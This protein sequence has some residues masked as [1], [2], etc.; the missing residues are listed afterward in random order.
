MSGSAI[1]GT[2]SFLTQGLNKGCGGN[3]YCV[4]AG[5]MLITGGLGLSGAGSGAG[6]GRPPRPVTAA[7][8][9]SPAAAPKA[10]AGSQQVYESGPTHLAAPEA[11][12]KTVSAEGATGASGA[13][14]GGRWGVAAARVRADSLAAQTEISNYMRILRATQQELEPLRAVVPNESMIVDM[15][16]QKADKL[17]IEQYGYRPAWMK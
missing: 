13:S 11:F 14:C 4:A 2:D 15:A 5:E 9:G 8:S 12:A 3:Q 7:R 10:R 17:F 1:L 6:S 16:F